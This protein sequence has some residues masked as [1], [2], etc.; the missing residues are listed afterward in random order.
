MALL[1]G[2]VCWGMGFY[3]L[4]TCQA[5]GKANLSSQESVTE[6]V[7]QESVKLRTL[8][9]PVGWGRGVTEMAKKKMPVQ[10]CWGDWVGRGGGEGARLTSH[11]GM[12]LPTSIPP[13]LAVRWPPTAP[14]PLLVPSK[15]VPPCTG[16]ALIPR[17]PAGQPAR[18]ANCKPQTCRSL[19]SCAAVLTSIAATPS[20]TPGSQCSSPTPPQQIPMER[21]FSFG[22][23]RWKISKKKCPFLNMLHILSCFGVF[24]VKYVQENSKRISF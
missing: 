1:G 12:L 16:Q 2:G 13:L 15:P 6:P 23:A 14:M 22:T 11:P 3:R 10:F 24:H 5:L 19:R 9:T 20:T 17:R 4:G 18:Q 7:I 8:I 21:F